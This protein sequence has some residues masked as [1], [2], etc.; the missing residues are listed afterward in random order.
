VEK[1]EFMKACR[2]G[3]EAIEGALRSLDRAFHNVLYRESLRAMRDA[4]AARD[5]VQETFIKVWGRCITYQGDSELL[6]WIRSILRHAILDRLRKPNREVAL[7]GEDGDLGPIPRHPD[8]K[9]VRPVA[10][11]EDLHRRQLDAC[12]ARCWSR[13][14]SAAPAHAAVM[15]W[16]VEDGMSN[17]DIAQL[18]GRTPGATRQFISQCRKRARFHLAEWHELAVGRRPLP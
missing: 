3:G 4:E 15:T 13:F 14:E 5:V 17:E 18:L 8:D 10:P 1:A 16:I 7:E 12:F 11:D 2:D 9:A 6:P